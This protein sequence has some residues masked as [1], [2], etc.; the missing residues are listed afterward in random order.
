MFYPIH[1][2]LSLPVH[3]T[4]APAPPY[5]MEDNS[6]SLGTE[7][8]DVQA[9]P[10]VNLRFYPTPG[11]GSEDEDDG[12]FEDTHDD[13]DIPIPNV[14]VGPGKVVKFAVDVAEQEEADRDKG[15]SRKELLTKIARLTD[16]LKDAEKAAEVEK[17]KRKK[18]ER[19]ILKLA[20]ELKKRNQKRD[21]DLERLEEVRDL[22]TKVNS[23]S[24]EIY[25]TSH[26]TCAC[27]H[28]PRYSWTK[29]NDIWSIIGFW[30]KR[31]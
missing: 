4:M 28:L 30:L 20:K 22:R 5:I 6:S 21:S 14:D 7:G 1:L 11:S 17:E 13:D 31:S 25:W 8:D 18:K 3:K 2:Q 9:S 24:V 23:A 26:L 15:R 16:M 27:A 12:F 19:N 29:R 10:V